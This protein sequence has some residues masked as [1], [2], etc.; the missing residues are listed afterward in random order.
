MNRMLS[1]TVRDLETER[2]AMGKAHEELVRRSE[3][4]ESDLQRAEHVA[5]SRQLSM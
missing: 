4:L 3:K 5:R 2:E 1:E